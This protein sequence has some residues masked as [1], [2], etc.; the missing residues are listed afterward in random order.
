MCVLSH[1]GTHRCFIRTM[2]VVVVFW[3]AV[4]ASVQLFVL[5]NWHAQLLHEQSRPTYRIQL[6]WVSSESVSS[7]SLLYMPQV[8]GWWMASTE[9]V[10]GRGQEKTGLC[11]TCRGFTGVCVCVCVCMRVRTHISEK[12]TLMAHVVLL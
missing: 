1:C 7:C 4:W 11:C 3:H 12:T 2:C 8:H 10:A 9:C 6:L 5:P